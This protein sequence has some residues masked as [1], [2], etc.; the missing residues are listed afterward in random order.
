V[1]PGIERLFLLVGGLAL[2]VPLFTMLI[3]NVPQRYEPAK[4]PQ[5]LLR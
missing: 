1:T 2:I 5:G 3:K 4:F